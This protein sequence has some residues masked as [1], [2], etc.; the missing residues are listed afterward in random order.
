MQQS[1]Q[2]PKC[3]AQIPV[4]QQFC[5][6]CGQHFEYRCRHCGSAINTLS[7]LCT[8]CGEKLHQQA[9]MPTWPAGQEVTTT[10]QKLKISH[11]TETTR[12]IDQV[13][14]Y[15]ILLAIIIFMGAIL[16]AI[17]TGTQGETANWFGSGFTFGGHSAPSTPPPSTTPPST[18]SSADN[19]L[20]PEPEYD[21][22]QYTTS[23]VLAAAKRMSPYCRLSS[24]RR[25]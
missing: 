25:S 7:G 10:P 21:L 22:P 1:F 3:G 18:S 5:N 2:C 11:Q 23:Q 15:L 19:Q 24:T 9:Q 16:Y 20:E 4:G 13:S 8:R 12:P 14:R 17:G 6:S